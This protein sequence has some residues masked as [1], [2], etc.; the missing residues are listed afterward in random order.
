MNNSIPDWRDEFFKYLLTPYLERNPIVFRTKITCVSVLIAFEPQLTGPVI[1]ISEWLV[2]LYHEHQY[3]NCARVALLPFDNSTGLYRSEGA[4]KSC[5]P[6]ISLSFGSF[7]GRDAVDPLVQRF[8][9]LD[10]PHGNLPCLR[11]C[12]E[13]ASCNRR[14]HHRR[15]RHLS[16]RLVAWPAEL[17]HVPRHIISLHACN[18]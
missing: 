18:C 1:E 7:A 2:H 8:E 16:G 15:E 5:Q 10:L 3:A 11:L 13:K 9:A 12:F 14:A 6:V 17:I 4:H